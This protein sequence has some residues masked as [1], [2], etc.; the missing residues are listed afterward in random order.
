LG[1]G[2][3]QHGACQRLFGSASAPSGAV[4]SAHIPHLE[5][6]RLGPHKYV[7]H[8]YSLML[9]DG[10]DRKRLGYFYSRRAAIAAAA[11][12]CRKLC[13]VWK[14]RWSGF[15]RKIKRAEYDARQRRVEQRSRQ[16]G[17]PR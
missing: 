6:V 2:R 12:L 8:A 4:M 1:T 13:V 9:F 16:F 11:Q 7:P 15:Y 17:V 10:A 5:I 14:G 3:A